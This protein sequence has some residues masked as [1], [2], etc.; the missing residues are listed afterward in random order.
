MFI[1]QYYALI[2]LKDDINNAL[3]S[4]QNDNIDVVAQY[5]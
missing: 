1:A 2:V 4:G 3:T 5:L